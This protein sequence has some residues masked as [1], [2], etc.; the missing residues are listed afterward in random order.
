M[1]RMIQNSRYMAVT[2]ERSEQGLLLG[3]R[4]AEKHRDL[5]EQYGQQYHELTWHP[6]I[7]PLEKVLSEVSRSV[8]GLFR[9]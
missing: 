7:K 3:S 8:R 6:L 1:N 2:V 5:V 4:W 9:I